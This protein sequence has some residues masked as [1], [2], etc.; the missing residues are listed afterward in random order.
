MKE[1]KEPRNE[2]TCF[3]SFDFQQSFQ[4]KDSLFN[5]RSWENQT[6][7]CR[8]NEIFLF[9]F[10]FFYMIL[11]FEL[12]ACPLQLEPFP[13]PFFALAIFQIGSYFLP[14]VGLEP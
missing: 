8:K 14:K 11:R 10:F 5:E 12:R 13:Q 4:E 1:K 3:L 9:S 6:S 2:S 7:T